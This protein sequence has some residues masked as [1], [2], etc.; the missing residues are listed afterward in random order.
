MTP[1]M[2]K[3]RDKIRRLR[4]RLYVLE[5]EYQKIFESAETEAPEKAE[6]ETMVA[7]LQLARETVTRG[8]LHGI[9]RSFHLR[10][11]T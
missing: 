1:G 11:G 4:D 5:V 2:E 3:Q 6:A 10:R 7:T 8:H 9:E